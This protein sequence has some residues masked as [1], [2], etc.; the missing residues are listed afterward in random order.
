M[1]ELTIDAYCAGMYRHEK[2]T[3]P[4]CS[5]SRSG[6]VIGFAGMPVLW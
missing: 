6:F 5:R 4:V 1:R 3:D 2:P